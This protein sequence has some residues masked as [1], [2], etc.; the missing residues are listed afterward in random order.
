MVATRSGGK[1]PVEENKIDFRMYAAIILFRWKLI[2]VCFLYALL[3]G[4]MYLHLAPKVYESS[5]KIMIYRDPLLSVNNEGAR[6][7]SL[8]THSYML[9]NDKLHQRVVDKLSEEWADKVGG[10]NRMMPK[11]M[12]SSARGVNPT[13]SVVVQSNNREYSRAFL[14]LLIEEHR[15]E[16]QSVQRQARN[17]AG[18]MLER[19]LARLEQEIESAEEDIIQYQRLHDIARVEARG[20]M[21]SRY[22]SALMQRRNQLTTELMLLEAQNPFLEDA[23]ASVISDVGQLTRQTG[24][25]ESE[26]DYPEDAVY[27]D[28]QPDVTAKAAA[29]DE[30]IRGFQDLRVQLIRLQAEEQELSKV[31]KDDHPRLR[32]LREDI[33]NIE[34]QLAALA[35]VQKR[36]LQ[37]RYQALTI[38]LNALETAEY[39]WQAKNLMAS[40]RQAEF[41]QLQG[42]LGRLVNHFD[43]LYTR[44]H[45]MRVSEELKAEH[46]VPEDVRTRGSPVWPDPFKI[47]S[48]ALAV[49]LGSGFGLA[50]MAQMLDNKVQS[51]K[52]VEDVLGVP[53]L[54]GIPF[55]ANSGLESAI[56][57]IVTEEHSTGA[58]EAYRALRTS[59]ISALR[60]ANEKVLLVTSAD[61]REGKTL[62]ALNMAI[63]IAQ[64]GKRVLLVDMDLRRGR[65]HRSLGL[66]REPG[67][68]D[69]L[70]EGGSLK[71]VVQESRVDNLY[72]APSG[73]GID[74]SAELL[75]TIDIR[76]FFFSVYDDFEYIIVDT[77][78]VL[79][80]T[81][82]V[83]LASQGI[84]QLLYVARVN[85]TPKPLL[86]Y[87]LDML[88]EAKV[89]GLVMNSIEMHKI[90]SLY[91]AY[92]Y[93]NYAYYSNA[94]SYGY[95]YYY[96]DEERGS[97]RRHRRGGPITTRL[98]RLWRTTRK[99]LMPED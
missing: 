43:T 45:D 38:Q 5:T 25:V 72:V 62:T 14:T 23:N 99:V 73:S 91:Y 97:G 13:L 84:G 3:A 96:Y 33:N 87:S 29:E 34:D 48:M 17:S 24:E 20:S 46:F 35:D 82:T 51:I 4:V 10:R 28:N 52:D 6:W 95:N 16:W 60:E 68:T 15:A 93:P 37:D 56:R 42:V 81:D 63:M 18:Q 90:S 61:S 32:E 83:I 9:N 85:F 30:S 94:Y 67:V 92:Q 65:I 89:L 2:T 21:E 19:E 39:K 1:S 36:R 41:R 31:L 7:T 22:L 98:R 74:D 50:F 12:V 66:K 88:K 57:P 59:V 49:G 26:V 55:W 70:R 47:L 58:I 8:R 75:Q 86:R 53:F 78:P 40:Q 76:D 27:I 71:S 11:I 77:S 79:R 44:L 64:M 80:V 69:V 54:G